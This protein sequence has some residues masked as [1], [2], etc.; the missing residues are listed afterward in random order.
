MGG[1]INCHSDAIL[2]SLRDDGGSG[3]KIPR[4]GVFEWVSGANFFGEILEWSGFAI[5]CWSLPAAAFAACTA[6][7]IGP[8]ALQHHA[9]YKDKFKEEYPRNR[10]ALIPYIL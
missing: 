3:Y 6:L 5:A 4:G 8:R 2:R 1:A 7:N 10:K 9:W